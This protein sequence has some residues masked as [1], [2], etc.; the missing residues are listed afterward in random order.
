MSSKVYN[1]G[2]KV[3]YNESIFRARWWTRNNTPGS[4]NEWEF[5][6]ACTENRANSAMH[7]LT[8]PTLVKDEITI[9]MEMKS[10][11]NVTIELYNLSGQL[12]RVFV[13]ENNFKGVKALQSDVSDLE[14][15]VY[16]Y[17]I[18]VNGQTVTKKLILTK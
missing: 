7:N 3:Y 18:K 15:G 2:D 12:I 5:I 9:S 8:Y 14:R 6:S 13:K 11:S 4:S 16:I 10:K 1:T 17:K